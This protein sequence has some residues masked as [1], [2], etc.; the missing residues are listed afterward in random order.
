MNYLK[1]MNPA[2]KG[3]LE[4][5][6]QNKKEFDFSKPANCF[7]IDDNIVDP[8][9]PAVVVN[10]AERYDFTQ[11]EIRTKKQRNVKS[12]KNAPQNNIVMIALTDS[13]ESKKLQAMK[14]TQDISSH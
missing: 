10:G 2:E 6:V 13:T 3:R 11:P 7:S 1:A 5:S 4:S 12:G 8:T 14:K 9:Q